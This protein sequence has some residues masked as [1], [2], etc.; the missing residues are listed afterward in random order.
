MKNKKLAGA[1]IDVF[2]EEPTHNQEL[3]LLDNVILTP[4]VAGV[5]KETLNRMEEQIISDISSFLDDKKS[6]YRLV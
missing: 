5:S 3:F 4:H 2:E 1:G 6:K